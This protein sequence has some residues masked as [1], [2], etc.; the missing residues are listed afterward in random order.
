[1]SSSSPCQTPRGSG[2]RKYHFE[3]RLQQDK[4][5]VSA[6]ENSLQSS[7]TQHAEDKL[8]RKWSGGDDLFIPRKSFTALSFHLLL[9]IQMFFTNI[10]KTSLKRLSFFFISVRTHKCTC[11]CH[12]MSVGIR[13]QLLWTQFP[14]S[15]FFSRQCLSCYFNCCP[16]LASFQAILLSPVLLEEVWD[17]K[18]EPPHLAFYKDSTSHWGCVARVFIQ[19]ATSEIQVFSVVIHCHI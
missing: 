1:M 11:T 16:A 17:N 13:G 6:A 12:S 15:M 4:P 9:N 3:H 14:H 8:N 7:T 19:W 10:F 2:W 5:L 18:Y